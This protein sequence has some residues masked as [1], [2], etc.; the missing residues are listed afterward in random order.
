MRDVSSIHLDRPWWFKDIVDGC[1]LNN[2]LYVLSGD[3]SMETLSHAMCLFFNKRI[4]DELGFE[5]PYEM[6][7]NGEWT[8][9][10]FSYLVR[11]GGKD[12]NGDG[13]IS[14]ADDQFGFVTQEWYGPVNILYAGGE[15]IISQTDDGSLK[16]SLY[17]TKTAEIFDE[18]FALMDNSSCHLM[19]AE[20]TPTDFFAEGRAMISSG[21]LGQASNYRNM[22]DNFGI[23]PF[24]LFDED[25]G[26]HTIS[27]GVADLA[28]IPQTVSDA[29][30]TGAITEALCAYGSVYVT[31]AFYDI[32][33]KTKYSRDDESAEMM[34]VIKDGI[35]FDI[36]YLAG[37][38]Y[39][40]G[41]RDIARTSGRDFSSWY[42]ARESAA[43]NMLEEFYRDYAGK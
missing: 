14:A 4:F 5:Y 33:L 26:Y 1:T 35:V 18:F 43:Q 36:G 16:L 7:K 30:R 22:D 17:S 6:V 9:D 25:D 12:L 10:E 34:D 24:P 40:N 29:E 42:A 27:N 37:S 15:R 41:G 13:V 23:L 38:P 8:F 2:R 39:G 20:D 31:P 11:K 21:S 28:V 19:Y 32:S 3:I